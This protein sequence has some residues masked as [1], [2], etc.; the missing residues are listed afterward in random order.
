[1]GEA[2]AV[3]TRQYEGMFILDANLAG[4][5]WDK[6]KAQLTEL[7]ENHGVELIRMEKWEERKLVYEVNKHKRGVYVLSFFK[8]SPDTL[9]ILRKTCRMTEWILRELI[10]VH[11]GEVTDDLFRKPRVRERE[12]EESRRQGGPGGSGPACSGARDRGQA[13]GRGETGGGGRA[14]GPGEARGGGGNPRE[15]RRA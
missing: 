8:A 6:A 9:T 12:R 5:H 4:K 15:A 1:M 11:S 10:L 14:A 13:C 3:K 2:T 7:M